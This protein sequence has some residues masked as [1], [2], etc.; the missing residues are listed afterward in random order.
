MAQKIPGTTDHTAVTAS[1][2]AVAAASEVA[3][4]RRDFMRKAGATA[5]FA[6]L[7]HGGVWAAGSDKPEKEEV[8][9]GFIPLTDCASAPSPLTDCDAVCMP[10]A[11]KSRPTSTSCT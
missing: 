4:P 9:I 1:T 7:G 3:A 5:L 2:T 11:S 8:K 10:G 6:T